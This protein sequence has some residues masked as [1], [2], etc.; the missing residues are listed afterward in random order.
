MRTLAGHRCP[1]C[2]AAAAPSVAWCTQC[3]ADLRP[4][5]PPGPPGSPELPG[6]PAVAVPDGPSADPAPA[7]WPCRSCG[8]A[9]RFDRSDCAGCGTAFLVD[10]GAG[11][12][13]LGVPALAVLLA[14]PRQTRI[15][16]SVGLLVALLVVLA[17]LVWATS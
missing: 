5:G 8:A 4:P 3:W 13:P 16:A 10:P 15:A 6:P 2:N 12:A 1:H 9:N 14:L 7:S 17:A 11:G